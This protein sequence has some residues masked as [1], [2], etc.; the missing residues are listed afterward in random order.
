MPAAKRGQQCASVSWVKPCSPLFKWDL[1]TSDAW[2]TTARPGPTSAATGTVTQSHP[3]LSILLLKHSDATRSYSDQSKDEKRH[4]SCFC[5]THLGRKYSSAA[6]STAFRRS[7][8]FR[9]VQLIDKF[10]ICIDLEQKKHIF[11]ECHQ[12]VPEAVNRKHKELVFNWRMW[13][14]L[15]QERILHRV[16]KEWKKCQ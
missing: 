14:S 3:G 6:R 2:K 13:A 8:F 7:T 15:L 12:K 16:T 1:Q 11:P 4:R 10:H 5:S 9:N